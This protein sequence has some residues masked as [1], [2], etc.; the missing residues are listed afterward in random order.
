[1]E[2]P[3][4]TLTQEDSELVSELMEWLTPEFNALTPLER[5]ERIQAAINRR[6]LRAYK[7]LS[8]AFDLRDV[9]LP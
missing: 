8:R 1:M 9:D 5:I 7:L 6:D 2:L 4:I 3:R